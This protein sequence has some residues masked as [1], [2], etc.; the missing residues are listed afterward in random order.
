MLRD[1]VGALLL[2]SACHAALVPFSYSAYTLG[3]RPNVD[4]STSSSVSLTAGNTAYVCI[5][6]N[7]KVTSMFNV[8]VDQYTALTVSGSAYV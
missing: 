4:S 7:G 8:V 1:L 3:C 5:N 2:F 6:I